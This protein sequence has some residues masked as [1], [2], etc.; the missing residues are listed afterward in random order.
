MVQ[1]STSTQRLCWDREAAREQAPIPTMPLKT[2]VSSVLSGSQPCVGQ[3]TPPKH[4]GWE[5]GTRAVPACLHP[6]HCYKL[7]QQ[8]AC[9][10]HPGKYFWKG[11]KSLA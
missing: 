1:L 8:F 11:I 3:H 7:A 5:E 4:C 6:R 2:Q 10:L 9:K